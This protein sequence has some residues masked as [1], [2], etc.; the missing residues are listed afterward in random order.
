MTVEFM[1]SAE[2]K[3]KETAVL[4]FVFDPQLKQVLLI[5]K[6]RGLGAGKIN[7]PGG[8][9]EPGETPA[10][11]A[12]RETMEEVCITPID[13]V[14]AGIV[15]FHFLDGYSLRCHVFRAETFSGNPAETPEADPFW[16]PIDR[17][18]Y[19]LMWQDDR[20][21]FPLLLA[22]KPFRGWFVFDG[23][24]MLDMLVEG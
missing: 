11:A 22:E 12:I 3:P 23:E 14:A 19:D 15:H 2:W 6:K 24:N 7:G 18:P 4:C 16:N 21:W 20:H 10:Q 8:R 17:I 1:R 5:K 13:P 9:I